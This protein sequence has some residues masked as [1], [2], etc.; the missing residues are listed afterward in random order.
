MSFELDQHSPASY[1][2]APDIQKKIENAYHDSALE[3]A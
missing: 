2:D 1:L 3:D